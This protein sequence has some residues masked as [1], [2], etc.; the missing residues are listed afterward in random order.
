LQFL[1]L[2]PDEVNG[3][4]TLE[5]KLSADMLAQCAKLERQELDLYLPKFKFEPPTIVLSKTLQS[6]GMKSAFD[7]P[8]GT[9]NFDKMAPAGQM[10]T[11]PFRRSFTRLSSPSMKKVLKRPLLPPLP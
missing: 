6:L 2:M 4:P 11:S 7:Q 3:L 9:A 10:I 1:V 5:S 8:R